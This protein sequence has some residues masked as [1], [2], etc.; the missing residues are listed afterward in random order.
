[1]R[2]AMSLVLALAVMAAVIAVAWAVL[3]LPRW[4]KVVTSAEAVVE[5]GYHLHFGNKTVTCKYLEPRPRSLSPADKGEY[6]EHLEKLRSIDRDMTDEIAW[7]LDYVSFSSHWDDSLE[8]QLVVVDRVARL[9]PNDPE[10]RRD[11][12]LG[13]R[14]YEDIHGLLLGISDSV[15][16]AIAFDATNRRQHCPDRSIQRRLIAGTIEEYE[17]KY[18]IALGLSRMPSAVSEDPAL[19][20]IAERVLTSPEND[21]RYIRLVI[22]EQIQ[23]HEQI[24]QEPGP[25]QSEGKTSTETAGSEPSHRFVWEEFH[26][27][28]AEKHGDEH[29]LFSNRLRLFHEGAPN[30]VLNRWILAKR[31]QTVRIL[32]ENIHVH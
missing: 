26:V 21:H 6:E 19:Q 32:E 31:S 11:R 9:D 20:E 8:K 22:D 29:L 15:E 10:V 14:V 1:M 5:Y 2:I 18:R 16:L 4:S 24:G 28:T 3:P 7:A 12:F 17:T 27:T 25:G 23:R 13:K 30:T